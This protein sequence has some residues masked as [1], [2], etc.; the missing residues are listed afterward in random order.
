MRTAPVPRIELGGDTRL[1]VLTGS[2]ISA[3]S[4]LATFR[5]AGG[6]W[7]GEPVEEVATPE[8]FRADP[9]RV[10]RFY[11][12]R[13]A[14]AARAAPNRAHLALAETEARLGE[15][16]LLA[17]QNVDGLHAAAGNRR[18]VELHGSLWRARCSRCAAAAVEDHGTDVSPPLPTCPACARP[19]ARPAFMR[20][21][22]VW[23]G[24]LLDPATQEAVGQFIDDA[25]M[26][27]ARLVFLAI[28]TSGHVWPAA[29]YVR[30]AAQAG[31]ETWLANLDPALNADWFDHVVA[32]PA[33]E[34]VPALLGVE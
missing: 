31:A 15:R 17:T 8:A 33:T 5:G 34:V 29:G 6:L 11:S 1:L 12:A 32:G 9:A 23:F 3:E 7:E 2:G 30:Y 13:R 27:Q 10:W 18:I 20:P 24:E 22:I 14:A 28:G 19:P 21:D 4:G 25:A 26:A 16:F